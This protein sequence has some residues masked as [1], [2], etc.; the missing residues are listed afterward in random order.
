MFHRCAAWAA[1]P[2]CAQVAYNRFAR[3]A[4][5]CSEG[6]AQTRQSN[7][8]RSV[9]NLKE[10]YMCYIGLHCGQLSQWDLHLL[11]VGVSVTARI[12]VMTCACWT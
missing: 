10:H 1:A 4:L 7:R 8:I 9:C 5:D 11:A 3:D 6:R 2:L 12:R